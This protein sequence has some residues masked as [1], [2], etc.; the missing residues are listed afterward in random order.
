MIKG[1]VKGKYAPVLRNLVADLRLRNY[2]GRTIDS[3][4]YHNNKFLEYFDKSPKY[5][6]KDDIKQYLTFLATNKE[7]EPTTFNLILSSIKFYYE[8]VLKKRFK[9]D[10]KR[11][12]LGKSLPTVITRKEIKQMIEVTSNLKHKLLITVLY[13]SGLRVSECLSLR[14]NH[15]SLE[16][17]SGIIRKGKGNK[18]RFF[19]L[20]EF[21]VNLV[22]KYLEKR[23]GNN[24]YLFNDHQG[25]L[26]VRSAQK[27][28]KDAAK[29][30]GIKK[31]V[32]CHALRS[33]FATH[34]IEDKV[35]ITT[36]QKLLGHKNI[37][38]TLGY[39]NTSASFLDDVVSPLDKIM[40]K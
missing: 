36:V 32:F 15:I 40:K 24:P 1:M 30:A 5:V 14:I 3:Y 18:D 12:K 25:H 20:S 26:S 13:S 8:E 23:K 27:I 9:V 34:L 38:T 33:S 2:S 21:A 4:V 39:L 37:K 28:V 6:T 11:A 16:N 35:S 17:R 7:V 22:N 19:K 31:R 10:F 29:K